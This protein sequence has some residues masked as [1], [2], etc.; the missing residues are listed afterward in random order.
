MTSLTN[1]DKTAKSNP[2]SN[3]LKEKKFYTSF[4][5]NVFLYYLY[6]THYLLQIT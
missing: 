5:S 2:A 6:L 1:Y 3:V 4:A